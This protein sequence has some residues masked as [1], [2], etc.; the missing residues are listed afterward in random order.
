MRQTAHARDLDWPRWMSLKKL[1]K[2]MLHE[3]ES[4]TMTELPRLEYHQT[5]RIEHRLSLRRH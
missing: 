5:K 3:T 4:P 1:A 2:E